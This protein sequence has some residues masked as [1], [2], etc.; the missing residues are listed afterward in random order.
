MLISMA[1]PTKPMRT[2]AAGAGFYVSP[3]GKHPRLQILTVEDLLG[4]GTISYPPSRQVNVTFRRAPKASVPGPE[5]LALGAFEAPV[6]RGK[7]PQ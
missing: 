4:G 2:E 3:W 7:R 6:T 1:D 5:Q